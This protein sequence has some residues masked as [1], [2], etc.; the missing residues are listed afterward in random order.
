MPASD[1]P[2]V[3]DGGGRRTEFGPEVGGGREAQSVGCH[4]GV[5]SRGAP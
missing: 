2:A 3:T 5:D 4:G 1:R